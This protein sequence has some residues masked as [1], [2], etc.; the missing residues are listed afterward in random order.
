MIKSL[1]KAVQH[2]QKL[3]IIHLDIKPANCVFQN[4]ESHEL[5]L[6]DF[7]SAIFEESDTP[8][9]AY[10]PQDPSYR[11]PEALLQLNV[12]GRQNQPLTNA[13][14]IWS[15]SLLV[16]QIFTGNIVQDGSRYDVRCVKSIS[17]RR[18]RRIFAEESRK[19]LSGRQ[20]DLMEGYPEKKPRQAEV[21]S[22]YLVCLQYQQISV[23]N[24]Y[25]EYGFD[26][27]KKIGGLRPEYFGPGLV[28]N[29]ALRG[30]T[31]STDRTDYMPSR[32]LFEERGVSGKYLR[33]LDFYEAENSFE[34]FICKEWFSSDSDCVVTNF[35]KQGL[36]LDPGVRILQ[37]PNLK[38]FVEICEKEVSRGDK[39]ADSTERLFEESCRTK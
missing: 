10:Q 13:A 37:R 9:S 16:N 30:V 4:V 6:V 17:D 28:N 29:V 39:D 5:V 20:W 14:D 18:V 36:V 25:D 19:V 38:K 32:D 24:S 34:P 8:S 11:A 15:L 31:D 7:G 35:V 21:V 22:T 2:L 27:L 23:H 12:S 3:K 33:K 1:C 26:F